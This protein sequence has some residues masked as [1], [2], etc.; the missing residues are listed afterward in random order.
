[1]RTVPYSG[2]R[3]SAP[4]AKQTATVPTCQHGAAA[5]QRQRLCMRQRGAALLQYRAQ[6]PRF[7]IEEQR[8]FLEPPLNLLLNLGDEFLRHGLRC[9]SAHRVLH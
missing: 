1:M 8:I 9:G 5:N 7:V 6:R 4:R 3:A 2:R